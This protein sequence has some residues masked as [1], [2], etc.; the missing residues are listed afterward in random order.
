MLLIGERHGDSTGCQIEKYRQLDTM[1][2]ELIV[3]D[4]VIGHKQ[5]SF[6]SVRQ[7]RWRETRSKNRGGGDR[8]PGT[9]RLGRRLSLL[10]DATCPHKKEVQP[11][12]Y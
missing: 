7:L 4:L 10:A 2:Y 12:H 8:G 5:S 6:V 9:P 1:Q 11:P 3:S